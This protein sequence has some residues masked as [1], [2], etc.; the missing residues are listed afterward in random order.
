M[1]AILEIRDLRVAYATPRGRLEAVRGVSL[2][3]EAGAFAALVGESGCGK[4]SL[5]RA[6]A[7]LA[8]IAAGVILRNGAAT[9]LTS[10]PERRAHWKDVQF[11]FQDGGA[12]LDPRLPISTSIGEAL[13]SRGVRGRALETAVAELAGEI[14]LSPEHLVR[15]PGALSGGQRQRAGIARALAGK[16]RVLIADEPTS[17]LDVSIK[18]QVLSVLDRER[19]TRGLAM[20]VVSHD[21]ALIAA[22]A[23][24]IHVMYLGLIVEEGPAA[25]LAA[26][27]AHPYTRALLA[28]AEPTPEAIA[29]PPAKGEPPSPLAP[30]AG[31]GFAARCPIAEAR[32]TTEAPTLASLRPDRRVACHFPL[33]K[34]AHG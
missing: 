30:P 20:L 17:A 31:C 24:T 34:D 18:A 33:V 32:C 21:L 19:R 15:R 26:A 10:L 22:A 12:S 11:V 16:P 25:A 28:A 3:L 2:A 1:S 14:G 13:E 7:G 9:A 6:I 4:S 5:A 8:P 23:D 27:P 29:A